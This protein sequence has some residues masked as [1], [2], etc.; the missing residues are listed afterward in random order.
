MKSKNLLVNLLFEMADEADLYVYKYEESVADSLPGQIVFEKVIDDLG[1]DVKPTSVYKILSFDKDQVT[2]TRQSGDEN[3]N[4]HDPD[5]IDIIRDWFENS[6]DVFDTPFGHG[7]F[8]NWNPNTIQ[9]TPPNPLQITPN[10]IWITQP[11][12]I[13]TTDSTAGTSLSTTWGNGTYTINNTSSSLLSGWG[14]TSS[15][16]CPW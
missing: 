15:T 11:Y 8:G 9:I 1:P 6:E 7:I 10:P 14:A 5:S 4:L 3:I 16:T 2:L 12:T 13:T